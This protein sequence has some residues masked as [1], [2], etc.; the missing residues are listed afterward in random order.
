[1]KKYR[2]K[3]S[4]KQKAKEYLE[5]LIVSLGIATFIFTGVSCISYSVKQYDDRMIEQEYTK[6]TEMSGTQ[7]SQN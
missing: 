7:I 1:M 5:L 6:K 4:I 2:L 3:K